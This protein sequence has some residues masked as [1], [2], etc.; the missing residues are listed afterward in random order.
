[1]ENHGK[2]TLFNKKT[3]YFYGHVQQLSNKLPEAKSSIVVDLSHYL[4]YFNGHIPPW[5][6][7]CS[8]MGSIDSIDYPYMIHRL[9]IDY[10][11]IIHIL[12]IYSIDSIDRYIPGCSSIPPGKLHVARRWDGKATHAFCGFG[13]WCYHRTRRR[14]TSWCPKRE[15]NVGEHKP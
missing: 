2:F 12:S 1:M 9:S 15:V 13:I 10:P 8:S 6:T 4:P 14:E 5:N 11:Y 7:P 3:H